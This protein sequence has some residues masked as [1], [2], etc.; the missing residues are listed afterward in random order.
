M[1]YIYASTSNRSHFSRG[2]AMGTQPLLYENTTET[3]DEGYSTLQRGVSQDLLSLYPENH[4]VEESR[5]LNHPQGFLDT[6]TPL[7]NLH[8]GNNPLFNELRQEFSEIFSILTPQLKAK[9]A[10]LY[11]HSLRVQ[12]LAISFT[13]TVLGLPEAEA[14]TIGLAAFFHDLGKMN[15]SEKILF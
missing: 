7:D 4:G 12:S 6:S 11:K 5:L 15:I 3:E 10:Q 9:D 8:R 1:P 2:I 13:T 14:L